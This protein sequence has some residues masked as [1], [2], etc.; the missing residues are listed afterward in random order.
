MVDPLMPIFNDYYYYLF[1]TFREDDPLNYF[2][3]QPVLHDWCNKDRGM[4][5]PVFGVVHIEDSLLLIG[6]CSLC[7]GS[8][9]SLLLFEWTI[10]ICLTPYNRK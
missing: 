2:S 5:Y 1:F 3:F 9:F 8:G 6:K 4:G 10:T 7:G